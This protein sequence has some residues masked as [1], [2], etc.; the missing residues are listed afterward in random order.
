MYI[1]SYTCYITIVYFYDLKSMKCMLLV[2]IQYRDVSNNRDNGLDNNRDSKCQYHPS[3]L[4][5]SITT[6]LNEA[7]ITS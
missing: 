6:H 3:L 1:R 5:P 4:R 7:L 2:S